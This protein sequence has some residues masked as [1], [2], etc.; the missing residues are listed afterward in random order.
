MVIAVFARTAKWGSSKESRAGETTIITRFPRGE[1]KF[2]YHH[3]ARTGCFRPSRKIPIF[4]WNF[5]ATDEHRGEQSFVS[6]GDFD[7][8][9][10]ALRRRVPGKIDILRVSKHQTRSP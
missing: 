7:E 1:R 4:F 2:P 8:P 5:T 9:Y 10:Q 3:P 6:T